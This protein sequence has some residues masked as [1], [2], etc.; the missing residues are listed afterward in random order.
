MPTL[1]AL[2]SVETIT[3]TFFYP[4]T[5]WKMAQ[6]FDCLCGSTVGQFLFPPYRLLQAEYPVEM[7]G[8]SR[9]RRQPFS[10]RTLRSWIYQPVDLDPVRGETER[11][12]AEFEK[13]RR[14]V[15]LR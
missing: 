1:A 9:R 5:E 4:S 10:S 7:L 15:D 14:A 12:K 8:T 6:P 11:T 3:V 13:E 2:T